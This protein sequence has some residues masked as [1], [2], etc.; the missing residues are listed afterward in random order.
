MP[1]IHTELQSF[2]DPALRFSMGHRVKPGGDEE[3][4]RFTL[5][6]VRETTWCPLPQMRAFAI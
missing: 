1:G 5:R 4:R 6:R 2:T 3:L